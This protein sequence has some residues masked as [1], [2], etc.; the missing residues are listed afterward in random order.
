MRVIL[1]NVSAVEEALY[2][3]RAEKDLPVG[4]SLLAMV[5]RAPR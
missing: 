3:A 2:A 1:I 5:G 4:A